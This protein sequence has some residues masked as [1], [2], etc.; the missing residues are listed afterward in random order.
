MKD[1]S[2]NMNY[3]HQK[4]EFCSDQLL[5]SPQSKQ[6]AQ[7]FYLFPCS[8]GFHAKCLLQRAKSHLLLEPSQLSAGDYITL[9]TNNDA[10]LTTL[11]SNNFLST[12]FSM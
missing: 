6:P 3:S 11:T 5:S 4:C 12:Q 2:Y 8:H 1:R 9:I 7:M 10:M